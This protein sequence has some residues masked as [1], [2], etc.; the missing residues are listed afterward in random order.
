MIIMNLVNYSLI[1]REI[2][3]VDHLNL[4]PFILEKIKTL[5]YKYVKVFLC[6][7]VFPKNAWISRMNNGKEKLVYENNNSCVQLCRNKKVFIVSQTLVLLRLL[8]TSFVVVMFLVLL[9]CM[10]AWR[11]WNFFV[12]NHL[13][14]G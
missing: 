14:D 12:T 5:E 7:K 3:L 1:V 2:Y 10:H 9:F 13:Y 4:N 11:G 6:M 8:K